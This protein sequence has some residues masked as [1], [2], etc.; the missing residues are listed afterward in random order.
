MRVAQSTV[1]TISIERKHS[2]CT[3]ANVFGLK[4]EDVFQP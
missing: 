4:I 1:W 2:E 3:I